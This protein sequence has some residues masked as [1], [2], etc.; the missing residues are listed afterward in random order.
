MLPQTKAAAALGVTQASLSAWERGA[1]A[2]TIDKLKPMA[3]LYG[4]SLDALVGAITG[5]GGEPYDSRIHPAEIRDQGEESH[6]AD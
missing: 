6:V 3:G 4:V 1:A 5:E 2:P